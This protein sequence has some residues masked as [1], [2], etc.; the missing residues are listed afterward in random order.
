MS[1]GNKVYHE[2]GNGYYSVALQVWIKI[3]RE[4]DVPSWPQEGF[5]ICQFIKEG[6]EIMITEIQGNL[7]SVDNNTY[8]LAHCISNCATMGAGIAMEFVRKYPG[9]KAYCMAR[10]NG[11]GSIVK[12]KNVYNLVTKEKYWHKPTY[13]TLRICLEKMAEEMAGCDEKHLAMPTLGCGIDKLEW[14]VVREIVSD[15]FSDIDVRVY[16]LPDR[17]K[18]LNCSGQGDKRYSAFHATVEVFG[19]K[20]KIENHY[21]LAKRFGDHVPANWREAKGRKPTHIEVGG[22]TFPVEML[23]QWYASLWLKY[24]DQHPKLIAHAKN[25]D[26]FI[27]PFAK[28]GCNNQAEVIEKYVKQGRNALYEECREFLEKIKQIKQHD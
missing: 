2:K 5:I 24:L 28:K 7:F 3:I 9:I 21:Q 16:S 6:G 25:F 22:M 10:A 11:P 26:V 27:D 8:V 15:I 19:K 17:V 4:K 12:Y 13:D 14:D 23:S 20:D 1:C 18:T